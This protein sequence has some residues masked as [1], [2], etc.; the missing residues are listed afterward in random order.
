LKNIIL[1]CCLLATIL[2]K[3]QTQNDLKVILNNDGT[4]T[5]KNANVTESAVVLNKYTKWVNP[6]KDIL[7]DN[8]SET[9]SIHKYIDIN[10]GIERAVTIN[11]LWLFGKTPPNISLKAINL[12]ILQGNLESKKLVRTPD[13]YAPIGFYIKRSD[14]ENNEK[15]AWKCHSKFKG[16]NAYGKVGQFDKFFFFDNEGNLLID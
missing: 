12:I 6:E 1:T 4:W 3:A 5:S 7:K 15:G 8:S 11:L 14:K 2:S 9:Y 10:N 13:S 16:L